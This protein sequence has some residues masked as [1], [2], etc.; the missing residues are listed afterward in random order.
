MEL[1][2]FASLFK[3]IKTHILNQKANI[4]YQHTNIQNHSEQTK[5]KF[6]VVSPFIHYKPIVSPLLFRS[7]TLSS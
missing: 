1:I 5:Q 2:N 7:L 3:T 4:Q 6:S